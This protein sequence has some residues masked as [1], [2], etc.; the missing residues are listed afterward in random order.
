[1]SDGIAC[2]CVK[3]NIKSVFLRNLLN[4]GAEY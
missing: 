2:V 4:N 1:M 3:I